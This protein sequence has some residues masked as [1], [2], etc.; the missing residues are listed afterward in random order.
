M[1]ILM[2]RDET[3]AIVRTLREA[4]YLLISEWPSSDGEE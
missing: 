1:A 4:A 3:G 2:N